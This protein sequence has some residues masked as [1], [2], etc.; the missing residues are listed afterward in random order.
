MELTEG[1]IYFRSSS[2]LI[3]IQSDVQSSGE[4]SDLLYCSGMSLETSSEG[5]TANQELHLQYIL[6]QSLL[7]G[8]FANTTPPPVKL[9]VQCEGGRIIRSVGSEK[10]PGINCAESG[11]SASHLSREQGIPSN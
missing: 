4:M 3:N 2:N 8:S 10:S 7:V 5:L 6:Q 11:T 9:S 1:E